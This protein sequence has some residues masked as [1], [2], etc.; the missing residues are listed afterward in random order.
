VTL[1]KK[2]CIAQNILDYLLQPFLVTFD[3][4]GNMIERLS[5]LDFLAFC[6]CLVYVDDFLN[7]FLQAKVLTPRQ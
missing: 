6:L 4:V 1:R 5:H 7:R 3:H 2:D